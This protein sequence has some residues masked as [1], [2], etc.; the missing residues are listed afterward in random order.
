MES[1]RT[2]NVWIIAGVHGAYTGW[3][4]TKRD[5]I[6]SHTHELELGWQECRKKGDRAIKAKLNFYYPS[7]LI[8]Q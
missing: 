2:E 6:Y 1:L 5:A 8:Q 4:H 3:W 7:Q